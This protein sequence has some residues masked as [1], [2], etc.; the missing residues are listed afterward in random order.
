MAFSTDGEELVGSNHELMGIILLEDFFSLFEYNGVQRRK[1]CTLLERDDIV[2][3]PPIT[4][5]VLA[6]KQ[7]SLLRAAVR[8]PTR[9]RGNCL[10]FALRSKPR[11]RIGKHEG[12]T[13]HESS[14]GSNPTEPEIGSV[15]CTQQCC[16]HNPEDDLHWSSNFDEVSC[17]IPTRTIDH[18]VCPEREKIT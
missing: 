7:P 11:S 17:L 6:L 9:C 16:C 2:L 10:V 3:E 14:E 13:D 5:N 4:G 15:C 8:M 18:Q 12:S 1:Q